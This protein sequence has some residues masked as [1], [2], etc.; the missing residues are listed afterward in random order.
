M[1]YAIRQ[2][3]VFI[4]LNRSRNTMKLIHAEDD[5][6]LLYIKR[7]EEGIFRLSAYKAKSRLYPTKSNETALEV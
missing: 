7:L 4:F 5:G 3:D 6:L 2:G 1:G